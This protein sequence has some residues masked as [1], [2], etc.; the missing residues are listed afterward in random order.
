MTIHNRLLGRVN[1]LGITIT[2]SPHHLPTTTEEYCE[3]NGTKDKKGH[4]NTNTNP[5]FLT[6]G[7]AE[8]VGVAP[9]AITVEASVVSGTAV[10][11]EACLLADVGGGAVTDISLLE[12]GPGLMSARR[13]AS[14]DLSERRSDGVN[15]ALHD[16]V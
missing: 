11:E 15:V 2:S 7:E 6:A 4:G 10:D 8:D 5:D 3:S 1:S 14:V 9:P 13:E 16:A 12:N